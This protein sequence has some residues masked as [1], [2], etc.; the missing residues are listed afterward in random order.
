MDTDDHPAF[1]DALTHI[2]VP[3]SKDQRALA[4]HLVQEEIKSLKPRENHTANLPGLKR[5][6]SQIDLDKEHSNIKN[7]QHRQPS[8]EL[9]QLKTDVPPPTS[10]AMDEKEIDFW[11]KCLNQVKIKLEYRQRQ[12]IDLD[13]MK[14]Y[15][16]P[17]WKQFL[18]EGEKNNSSLDAELN[19]IN[20]QIQEVNSNMKSDQEQVHKLLDL[21][22]NEWRTLIEQNHMLAKE[23]DRLK[24]HLG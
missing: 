7:D 4:I 12:A 11:H 15:G 5:R 10:P 1:V 6:I 16:E 8:S 21:L 19:E 23:I 18:A 9:A 22:G 14:N 2:D 3:I 24:N 20:K 13:L 17:T